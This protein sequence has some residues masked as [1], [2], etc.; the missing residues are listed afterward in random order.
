MVGWEYDFLS[1]K[2]RV[3]L[4]Q[5]FAA[6]GL[7]GT[8]TARGD[9]LTGPCP[10]H[11]GDNKH[12]FV[13]SRSKNLWYCFSG[14]G[15]EGRGGGGDVLEFVRR[16]L[17]LTWL[18]TG[19]YLSFL[20]DKQGQTLLEGGISLREGAPAEVMGWESKPRPKESPIFRAYRK[21]LPL[22]SEISFLQ[23]KGI[24]AE[25]ARKYEVGAYRGGGWLKGCL[26][27]RLFEPGGDPV[28]Y[29]GRRLE[30]EEISRYGKWKFPPGLP[31]SQLL[32]NYHRIQG[33]LNEGLWVTECPWGVLR[34]AQLNVPAV[35][36]FGLHLSD[37]RQELLSKATRVTLLLDGD[38]PGR[39]ASRRLK[40]VLKR[41]VEVRV[42]ALP[43]GL[44]PDELTDAELAGCVNG[45]RAEGRYWSERRGPCV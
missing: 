25:T 12:A 20:A 6:Q 13:V 29:A 36:L 23:A 37:R 39:E 14:C 42:V 28:G 30:P 9:R 27:V 43:E 24:G 1:L 19:R 10:L 11:G 35:A 40:A 44:D 5:V 34:L 2:S 32:Y 38:L 17:S 31:A 3:S 4:E 45:Q 7:L 16:Y 22:E 26:G 21:R 8:F 15:R 33:Q 41:V 18:E